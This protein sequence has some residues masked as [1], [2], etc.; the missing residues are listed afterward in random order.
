MWKKSPYT[1]ED[2]PHPHQGTRKLFFGMLSF[3]D[4]SELKLTRTDRFCWGVEARRLAAGQSDDCPPTRRGHWTIPKGRPGSVRSDGAGQPRAGVSGRAPRA[5]GGRSRREAGAAQIRRPPPRPS[6]RASHRSHSAARSA[7]GRRG[8]G[9]GSRT[10]PSKKQQQGPKQGARAP[11]WRM[12]DGNLCGGAGESPSASS[13]R[14][15]RAQRA[16]ART[17]GGPH[18]RLRPPLLW[19][20]PTP[21]S[22]S[23]FAIR[24]LPPLL[25]PSSSID[26]LPCSR[27][28]ERWQGAARPPDSGRLPAA[29]G[30]QPGRGRRRRSQAQPRA[31][32][33]LALP[34]GGPGRQ[35]PGDLAELGKS[36]H[37][38]PESLSLLPGGAEVGSWTPCRTAEKHLT[39]ARG[40]P[41]LS[42]GWSAGLWCNWEIAE[43]RAKAKRVKIPVAQNRQFPEQVSVDCLQ[44]R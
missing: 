27:F 11:P 44:V 26:P 30:K 42:Q 31:R 24:A 43:L 23:K 17:P 28:P 6:A 2:L 41:T 37:S 4:E 18:R 7:G 12:L 22:H 14:G 5:P 38:N 10:P 29:A 40:G 1:N 21:G 3:P 13:R 32:G 19:P 34:R 25:P 15:K 16:P 33:R 35:K 20:P 8:A 36:H 9:G 39:L